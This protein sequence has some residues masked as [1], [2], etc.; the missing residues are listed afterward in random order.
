MLLGSNYGF[1]FDLLY[2]FKKKWRGFFFLSVIHKIIYRRFPLRVVTVLNWGTYKNFA[3]IWS[4][5][6][7]SF[8]LIHKNRFKDVFERRKTTQNLVG[9]IKNLLLDK[10]FFTN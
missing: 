5:L 1:V 6:D 3:L 4:F 10:I 7:F 8:T 9:P 2:Y